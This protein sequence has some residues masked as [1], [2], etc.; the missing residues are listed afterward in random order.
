MEIV[1]SRSQGAAAGRLA[2][3]TESHT[4]PATVHVRALIPRL[5]AM[6]TEAEVRC[7]GDRGE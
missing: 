7:V 1:S 3:Q 4:H 6:T 5:E 2:S